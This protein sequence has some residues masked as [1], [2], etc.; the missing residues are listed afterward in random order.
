MHNSVERIVNEKLCHVP[1]MLRFFLQ[2]F[3]DGSEGEPTGP[4]GRLPGSIVEA[5]GDVKNQVVVVSLV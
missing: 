3:S 2:D 1:E 4:N 5:V